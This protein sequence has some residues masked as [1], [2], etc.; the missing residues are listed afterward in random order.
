MY[1][2]NKLMT[3]DVKM[4]APCLPLTFVPYL[5]LFI[6]IK[7]W[8]AVSAAALNK[9]IDIPSQMTAFIQLTTDTYTIGDKKDFLDNTAHFL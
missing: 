6:G 8:A 4:N 9:P 2:I 5:A 3:I 7:K 1:F